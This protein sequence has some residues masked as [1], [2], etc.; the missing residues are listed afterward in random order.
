M[1]DMETMIAQLKLLDAQM[2]ARLIPLGLTAILSYIVVYL[3]YHFGPRQSLDRHS[4]LKKRYSS[5]GDEER[6]RLENLLLRPNPVR[7]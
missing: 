7:R 5:E 1:G 3:F 6:D 2:A 4:A